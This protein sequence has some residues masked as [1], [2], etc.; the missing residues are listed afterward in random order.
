MP[1]SAC[2]SC[3]PHIRTRKVWLKIH[4][5]EY[6]ISLVERIPLW[7]RI[8][9]WGAAVTLAIFLVCFVL[10]L[11]FCVLLTAASSSPV[12][13]SVGEGVAGS[14]GAGGSASVGSGVSAF[15]GA[16]VPASMGSDVSASV[17]SGVSGSVGSGVSTVGAGVVKSSGSVADVVPEQPPPQVTEN[18]SEGNVER[19]L[20]S[21]MTRRIFQ[22][23]VQQRV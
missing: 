20:P 13:A 22:Q 23:N 6:L 18:S 16:G 10:L 12:S 5:S 21:K 17:G 11:F 4:T 3:Y 9:D 7:F 15:V 2:L 8:D 1:P 14:V 19:K